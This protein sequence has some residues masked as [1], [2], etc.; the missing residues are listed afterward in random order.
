LRSC[1]AIG[2]RRVRGDELD[3]RMLGPAAAPA[4][5]PHTFA[6]LGEQP[7]DTGSDGARPHDH[8]QRHLGARIMPRPEA[9]A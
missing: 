6:T 8:V 5:D 1:R 3:R 7:R 9:R 4:D 2:L